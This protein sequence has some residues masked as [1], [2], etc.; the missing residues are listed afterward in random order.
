VRWTSTDG[1]E[2]V[3]EPCDVRRAHRDGPHTSHVLACGSHDPGPAA[4]IETGDR[5]PAR[6][7]KSSAHDSESMRVDTRQSPRPPGPRS[8]VK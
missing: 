8:V 2:P 4:T 5:T 6:D 1:C 3:G 7:E